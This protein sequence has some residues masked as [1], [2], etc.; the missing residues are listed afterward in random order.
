M[1]WFQVSVTTIPI[2]LDFCECNFDF[3][4]YDKIHA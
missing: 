2:Q 3:N 4:V 1:L